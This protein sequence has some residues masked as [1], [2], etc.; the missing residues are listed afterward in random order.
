MPKKFVR[1][2]VSRYAKL[3]KNRKKLQKWRKPKGRDSKMRLSMKSYPASPTVG[4]KSPKKDSGKIDGMTPILVHNTNELLSLTK[5]QVAILASIGARKKL[6]VIKL[7]EEK[8][9]QIINL[10]GESKK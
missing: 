1:Q 8:K 3:G 4:H 5:G 6:E 10:K 9:I 7:A 2:D